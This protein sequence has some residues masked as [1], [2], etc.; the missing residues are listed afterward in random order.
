[1]RLADA[2][3][4]GSIETIKQITITYATNFTCFF[5]NYLSPFSF[6]YSPEYVSFVHTAF[7]MYFPVILILYFIFVNA[8]DFDFPYFLEPNHPKASMFLKKYL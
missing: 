4:C 6:V 8:N 3:L 7:H 5:I 2:I 1:M